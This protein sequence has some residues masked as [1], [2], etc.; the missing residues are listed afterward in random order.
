MYDWLNQT[1]SEF[2]DSEFLKLYIDFAREELVKRISFRV[3]K[4]IEEGAIKE[5]K[6]F[7]KL[8]VKKI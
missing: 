2:K 3:I 5:V 7:I 1:K 4:M 8:K 6:K